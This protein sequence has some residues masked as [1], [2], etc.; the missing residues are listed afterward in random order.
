MSWQVY[1]IKTKEIIACIFDENE[2][3]RYKNKQICKEGY[4]VIKRPGVYASKD[5][6]LYVI[7]DEQEAQE[8]YEKSVHIEEVENMLRQKRKQ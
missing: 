6:K 5:G 3:P 1:N 4:A 8:E 2:D 7:E